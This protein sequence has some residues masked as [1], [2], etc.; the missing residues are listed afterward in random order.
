MTFFSPLTRTRFE[1]EKLTGTGNNISI[2][3]HVSKLFLAAIFGRI[4]N[5]I[6]ILRSLCHY[7][8]FAAW[9]ERNLSWINVKVC[10]GA[11]LL[12]IISAAFCP[13]P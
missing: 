11:I 1:H 6:P 8:D 7:P 3:F 10:T 13:I 9:H 2:I 12:K 4:I 5:Y